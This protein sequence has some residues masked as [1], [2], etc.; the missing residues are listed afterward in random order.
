MISYGDMLDVVGDAE[1]KNAPPTPKETTP[2]VE[3]P[4]E[5]TP[6]VETPKET[7]KK[8]KNEDNIE[9]VID[10]EEEEANEN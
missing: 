2:T 8:E 7:A 4:K 10:E 9:D 3:T 5:T 1:A 6:T